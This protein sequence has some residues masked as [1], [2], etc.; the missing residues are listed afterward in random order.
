MPPAAPHPRWGHTHRHEPLVLIQ[1]LPVG[2]YEQAPVLDPARVQPRLLL[3]VT[4]HH[5]PRVG[6]KLHLHVAGPQLPQ[7]AL[8]GRDT[9]SP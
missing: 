6:Q 5:A 9:M 4:A 8:P 1:T 3:Q 7:Q 2:R